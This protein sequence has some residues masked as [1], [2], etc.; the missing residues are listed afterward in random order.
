MDNTNGDL[1]N[2]MEKNQESSVKFIKERN[3]MEVICKKAQQELKLISQRYD[4]LTKKMEELQDD[5]EIYKEESETK[6]LEMQ[7][8]QKQFD[9]YVK[10]FI[11]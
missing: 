6:E 8:L 5:I 9:E 2:E 10:E 4:E 11:K 7:V 3:E 1:L